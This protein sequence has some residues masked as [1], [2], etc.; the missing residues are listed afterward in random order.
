[1]PNS[2]R[3]QFKPPS[4]VDHGG[5]AWAFQFDPLGKAPKAPAT[6]CLHSLADLSFVS[7]PMGGG[8]TLLGK[9]QSFCLSFFC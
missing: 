8:G 4:Q 6:Y 3:A 7:H 9:K 1:M 5:A 2:R